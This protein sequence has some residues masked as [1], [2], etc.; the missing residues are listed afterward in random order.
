MMCRPFRSSL[1]HSPPQPLPSEFSPIT[2]ATPIN[3][4][5]LVQQYLTEGQRRLLSPAHVVLS[6]IMIRPMVRSGPIITLES[7]LLT[8]EGSKGFWAVGIRDF[9]DFKFPL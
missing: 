4:K 8:L 3:H 1:M 7:R 9:S 2:M 5:Q 6:Q